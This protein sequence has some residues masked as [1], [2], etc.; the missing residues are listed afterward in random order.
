MSVCCDFHAMQYQRLIPG[1][2]VICL[3]I[4]VALPLHFVHAL[5]SNNCIWHRCSQSWSAISALMQLVRL[6]REQLACKKSAL[7]PSVMADGG[8]Y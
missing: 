6:Q 7:K 4:S 2:N 3:Q 5:R 8:L 1:M